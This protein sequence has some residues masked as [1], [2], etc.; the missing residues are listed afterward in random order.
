MSAEDVVVSVVEAALKAAIDV[1]LGGKMD[2]D[3]DVVR[4][5]YVV[6]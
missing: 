4:G 5:E 1:A 3:V 2:D 6:D